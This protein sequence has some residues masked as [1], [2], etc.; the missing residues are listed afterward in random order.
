[1]NTAGMHVVSQPCDGNGDGGFGLL[2]NRSNGSRS[3][4]FELNI[5]FATPKATRHRSLGR[6]VVQ[7][8]SIPHGDVPSIYLLHLQPHLVAD[9][10]QGFLAAALVDDPAI[11]PP[12]TA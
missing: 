1:M 6:I 3:E 8:W 5:T 7:P 10:L 9:S 12:T 4:V 11:Y 2:L